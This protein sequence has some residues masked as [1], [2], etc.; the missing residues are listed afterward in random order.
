[1]Q[2][3]QRGLLQSILYQILRKN[4][5]IAT[6]VCPKRSSYEEWHIKELKATLELVLKQDNLRTKFCFFIDG[7]DEY[8]GGEEELVNILEFFVSNP[9][10]KLCVSSRPRMVLDERF[11]Q[12]RHTLIIH[13]FT[14][15]DMKMYVRQNLE[16]NAKFK[17]LQQSSSSVCDEIIEKISSQAKGVWL[18]VYLV[19]RSLIVEVN[20]D[21][22]VSTLRKVLNK[23]PKDLESY[24]T[25]IIEDIRP[26]H[27]Q[28]MAQIFLITIAEVQPLPLFVF[29]LL[30][31]ERNNIKYATESCISPLSPETVETVEKDWTARIHNRCGDLVTVG[32]ED[33]PVFLRHPVD[34]LHRTVGDFLQDCY[35]EKL[36]TLAPDFNPYVSLCKMMLF[37]LKGL[38][39]ISIRDKKSITT[40]IA[41]VDELLYYAR[42]VEKRDQQTES[43][44]VDVLDEVDRVNIHH[45]SSIN[46]HWT[47]IRDPP[48]TRGYD[49]YREGG[50]C[51][52]LALAVQARLVKYVRE[53]LRA[54]PM[55][56]KNK[57]GRP[58]L[59]YALRPRRVTPLAMPYHSERDD[60]PV[61]LDMVKLLLKHGSHPNQKVHLNDGRT[62]W[63]LFLVSCDEATRRNEAS[64]S[65]KDAWYQASEI[66]INHGASPTYSFSIGTNSLSIPAILERVF[67]KD[68]ASKL[69]QL[70]QG[71]RQLPSEKGWISWLS[72]NRLFAK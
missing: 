66:L 61:D 2:R 39:G 31:K 64:L 48:T 67:G 9:N 40:M 70:P 59:D 3:S 5:S 37:L 13:D 43:V 7:L 52:F 33:H 62:V 29:S 45:L 16:K 68:E 57:R 55:Q 65:T 35:Y 19:T 60:P 36:E 44:L 41:I 46:N 11:Q 12:R 17:K 27:R 18:W 10:V 71:S 22:G 6:Q 47:H 42:E 4:P 58:L 53:K 23:F 30:E 21:E 24:F 38:P 1:M 15:K 8:G 54:S 51:N 34:Y 72:L 32:Y 50:N 20:R 28:E 25:A 56:L 26:G 49:E 69:Q 14:A 63:E